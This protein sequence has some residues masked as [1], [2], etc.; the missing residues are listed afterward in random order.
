MKLRTT[1]GLVV[2]FLGLLAYVYFGEVRRPAASTNTTPTPAPVWSLAVDQVV[3]LTVRSKGQ[4]TRLSRP[5]GGEWRLEAPVAD[6]ADGERVARVVDELVN[7]IPNRTFTETLGTLADYGLEQPDLEVGVRLAAGQ[8][9]ALKIG[10]ANPQDTA[11][12]AQVQGAA[13]VHL[14]PSSLVTSLREL[15]TTPPIKPTPTATEPSTPTPEAT[16]SASPGN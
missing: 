11:Y 10:A 1:L 3:G 7:V 8:S 15:L 12:Y 4:E 16:P 2:V 5:A 14:L 13:V 9:Q 6:A